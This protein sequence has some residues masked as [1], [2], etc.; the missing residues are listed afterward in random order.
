MFLFHFENETFLYRESE[1][2]MMNI[3]NMTVKYKIATLKNLT[4]M[5]QMILRDPEFSNKKCNYTY[6]YIYIYTYIYI[7]IYIY[8]DQ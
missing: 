6:I 2:P 4:E 7:Y 1:L 8:I 3:I 5:R